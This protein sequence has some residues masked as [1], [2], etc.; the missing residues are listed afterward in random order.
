MKLYSAIRTYLSSLSARSMTLLAAGLVP[1]F[2]ALGFLVFAHNAPA[3]FPYGEDWLIRTFAFW[4]DSVG[5]SILL[6]LSGVALL[7]YAEK[8]DP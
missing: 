3:D 2:L 6:L 4:V 8:H 7:D 5:I 1:I